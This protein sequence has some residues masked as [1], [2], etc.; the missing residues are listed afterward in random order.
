MMEKCKT[1]RDEL[2][3]F[4]WEEPPPD[5]AEHLAECA[6]CRAHLAALKK[7]PEEVSALIAEPGETL[8]EDTKRAVKERL[9][10]KT[11]AI[12]IRQR[13]K[14]ALLSLATAAAMLLGLHLLFQSSPPVN[15]DSTSASP[16]TTADPTAIEVGLTWLSPEALRTIQDA[17][18]ALEEQ[19]NTIQTPPGLTWL[20]SD[21][22][23]LINDIRIKDPA[24]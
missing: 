13:R 5:V 1:I 24:E 3:V 6:A 23:N 17:P 8:V 19:Q 7:I 15:L 20:A 2:G 10:H 11:D 16:P 21:K 9:R 14:I 4:A 12:R 18:T 22:L